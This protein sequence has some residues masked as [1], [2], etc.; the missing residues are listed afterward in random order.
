M[1]KL[2]ALALALVMAFGLA[3][4]AL[5]V[6]WAAAPM[7][8]SASPFAIEVIKLGVNSD[9]TGTKYYTV[10][11][12][13]AAYDFSTIYYAIKLVV[14]S[15]ANANAYYGNSG[16]LSGDK[17]KVTVT[18]TNVSGKGTDTYYVQ[19]TDATQTLWLNSRTGA[20]DASWVTSASN[21]CGCGDS[22]II[23]AIAS[24]TKEVSIKA[25]VG[26]SG[27]LSAINVGN[28][29]VSEKTYYGVVPCVNCAAQTLSGFLFTSDCGASGAFFAT[30][31]AGKVTGA[32]AVNSWSGNTVYQGALVKFSKTLYGWYPNGTMTTCA[33]SCGVLTFT[34]REIPTGAKINNTWTKWD[35]SFAASGY[36]LAQTEAAFNTWKSL[37][38]VNKA[39]ATYQDLFYEDS[40]QNKV[41]SSWS[42]IAPS[43]LSTQPGTVLSGKNYSNVWWSDNYLSG[44]TA[45]S[46]TKVEF[47]YD[48]ATK[49]LFE[50][51]PYDV[52]TPGTSYCLSYNNTLY[53]KAATSDARLYKQVAENVINCDY[54]DATM[55]NTLNY[56]YG[57][58]GFTYADLAAGNVYMT[59]DILLSNFGFNVSVCDTKTWGAY[60][61]AITV[62]PVAE[63]PATGSISFAGFALLVLSIA[64]A[65]VM[66]KRVRG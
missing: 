8:S 10:V 40:Y 63:V 60:T 48:S 2:L 51:Y 12:N 36:T 45:G 43:G 18:Y 14:P 1:K 4:T 28:F 6:S 16:F 59:K 52:P 55:L 31:T 33:G 29:S 38:E 41:A 20:F 19:L 65:A 54:S 32:Y 39:G 23:S 62:T 53:M 30:N 44:L 56:L 24:G 25:C 9:V 22:H 13:A 46:K 50:A 61:A 3:S 11:T 57:K 7:S 15:Y 5:S 47:T 21:N 17:A 49:T 58:L 64:T 26:A 34:K 66:K 27:E 37:P 35:N 42:A